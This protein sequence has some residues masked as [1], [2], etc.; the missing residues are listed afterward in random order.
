MGP[1]PHEAAPQL[2]NRAPSAARPSSPLA[3]RVGAL[4]AR[5]DGCCASRGLRGEG[6]RLARHSIPSGI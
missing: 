3:V 4:R 5:H 1:R 6:A 2:A